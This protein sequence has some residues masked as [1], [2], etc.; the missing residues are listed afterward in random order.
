MRN[1][2]KLLLATQDFDLN[3][4]AIREAIM[5]AKICS[6]TLSAVSVVETNPEFETVAPQVVEKA[7]IKTREHLQA[8]KAMAAK[9]GVDCE[10]VAR[11]GEEAYEFIVEEAAKRQCDMIVIG[12]KSK[13]GLQRLMMGSVTAKVIAYAACNILVVPDK[14][15]V[16]YKR[17]LIATDGSK[18][19]ETA[20]EHSVTIAKKC[21]SNLVAVA[22]VP[23]RSGVL[24]A[25]TKLDMLR[26]ESDKEFRSAMINI[27]DIAEKEGV[28][29]ENLEQLIKGDS[30]YETI[31]AA[32][33]DKNIDLIVVGSHGKTGLDRVLL[34]SVA[35]RVI[36]LSPCAVLVVKQNSNSHLI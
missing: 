11:R 4:G 26:R 28:A 3:E 29:V 9:E 31:I 15:T 5:L 25:I 8:V 23:G 12:R 18:H 2:G 30:P 22:A 33:K 10:I 6:G 13:S 32:A 27:R 21:G 7:E 1:F 35:E 14:A 24:A 34:G 19:S 16:E 17:I 20:A 36:M